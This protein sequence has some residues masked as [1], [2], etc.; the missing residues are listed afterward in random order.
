MNI[1]FFPL[2]MMMMISSVCDGWQKKIQN[3]LQVFGGSSEGYGKTPPCRSILQSVE[4][5]KSTNTI[6]I[7]RVVD[8]HQHR[9]IKWKP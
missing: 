6:K 7:E 5:F 2:M 1:I 8:C 3:Q 9:H 4:K